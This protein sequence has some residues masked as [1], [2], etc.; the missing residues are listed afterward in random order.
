MLD[1]RF[2][3]TRSTESMALS[4]TDLTK[5]ATYFYLSMALCFTSLLAAATFLYYDNGTCIY[6]QCDD[7]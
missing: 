4:V 6:N 7:T 1:Q 5:R 2:L 3:Q